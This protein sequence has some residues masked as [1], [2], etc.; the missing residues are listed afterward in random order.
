[1]SLSTVIFDLGGVLIDWNPR[2]LYRRLIADEEQMERFLAT[3]C[4]QE[5]NEQ[6]DAGRPFA[7]AVA[8]LTEQYPEHASLIQ[9]YDDHWGDMV[10]GSVAGTVA[11]LDE[12]AATDVRLLALTN[13]S[14]EKFPIARERFEFLNRFEG[15]VVSGTENTRKPYRDIYD[16]LFERYA[17]NP[18][19]AVFIDD[20]AANVDMG[21]QLGLHAIRFHNPDALRAEL[22]ALGLL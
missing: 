12:L 22:A 1:V 6:Q 8:V 4:T 14:A 5:W 13:W 15:I 11:V 20:S 9:A 2:Y 19:T 17:V 3:I 10:S 21:Q 18:E 16:I 7:T